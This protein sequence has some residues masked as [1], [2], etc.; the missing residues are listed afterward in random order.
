MD[1]STENTMPSLDLPVADADV[2]IR[3]IE[4]REKRIHPEAESSEGEGF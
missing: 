3:R 2:E 1:D 4:V